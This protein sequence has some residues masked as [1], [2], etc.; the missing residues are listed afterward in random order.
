MAHPNHSQ[1]RPASAARAA[2]SR[3]GTLLALFAFIIYGTI[4]TYLVFG[5]HYYAGDAQSRVANAYYVLFSQNPH[6]GAIGFVWNPLPSLLELPL[7]ALHPWIPAVVSRGLAGDIVS[8]VLGAW[9][10]Y[11]LH[12]ILNGWSMNR[13]WRILITVSFALNPLIMLYGANGMSDIMWVACILGTYSGIFDYLQS[14]SLHRL[15]SA[16]LWLVAGFGMRYEAVPFGALMIAALLWTQWDKP[17]PQRMGSAILFGAPIV[18]GG[19][20]W[21]YFS[22]L[23]MKNPLYFL[24]SSYGNLAQTS[25]GA[26]MTSAMAHADHHILRSFFYV[27]HFGLFFF[28][29]FVAAIWWSFGRHRDPR[30]IVLVLGTIGAELLELVFAYQGHLGEWDRYFLEFIPNGVLLFALTINKVGAMASRWSK[31]PMALLTVLLTVVVASGSAG[32]RI[33][34]AKSNPGP[35]RRLH[36]NNRLERSIDAENRN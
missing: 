24:N 25:T 4:S 27:I 23:I 28:I 30:A 22:W 19:G 8:A 34:T 20:V 18:F 15:V 32:N 10:V 2:R 5:I 12:H 11:H 29:G 6:L 26:Y 1:K 33:G 21:I 35:P 36:Y 14:G 3:E 31:A 13:F 16:G 9:G 17:R 7:V